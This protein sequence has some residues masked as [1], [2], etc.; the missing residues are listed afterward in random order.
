MDEALRA[1]LTDPEAIEHTTH[2]TS[3]RA[4]DW[5]VR[6]VNRAPD[7]QWMAMVRYHGLSGTGGAGLTLLHKESGVR[8]TVWPRS[9]MPERANTTWSCQN[10]VADNPC[11]ALLLAM[12]TSEVTGDPHLDSFD[13]YSPYGIVKK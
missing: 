13:I 4:V 8:F 11:S 9:K 12:F 5:L 2:E 7:S 1:I 6:R 10:H 3:R